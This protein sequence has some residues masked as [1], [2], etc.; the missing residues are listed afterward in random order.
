MLALL[1]PPG[2]GKSTLVALVSRLHQPT[3]GRLLL[4]G[5]PLPAYQH[6]Y[7]CRQVSSHMSPWLL[8]VPLCSCISAAIL[9]ESPDIWV[10]SHHHT[11]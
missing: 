11:P 5:H 4:D 3:A 6:S 7:L 2:A 8:V 10:P 9:I 1:G